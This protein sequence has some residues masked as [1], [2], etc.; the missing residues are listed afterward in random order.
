MIIKREIYEELVS[1]TKKEHPNE[2]SALLFKNN[3]IVVKCNP[4][5]TSVAHFEGIDPIWIQGLIL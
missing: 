3:T 5:S 4:N 1:L 2:C